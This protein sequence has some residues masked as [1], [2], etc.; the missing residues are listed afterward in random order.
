MI[1]LRATPY[2]AAVAGVTP[3]AQSER[4]AIIDSLRG[5]ALLGILLMN[6]PVFALPRQAILNLNVRN[7]YSG[8]NYYTWWIVNGGFEGTMRA[9][10][11]LLFGAGCILL[12]ERLE[13]KNTILSAADI[14]YR[15]L[16]WLLIFGLIDA[17]IF[18]WYGDILFSYAV[19]GLFLFPFRKLKP[20][21]L[22]TL[23]IV[24]ML[25]SGLRSTIGLYD[26]ASVRKKGEQVAAILKKDSTVK[27]TDEQKADKAKYDGLVERR[28]IENIRKEADKNVKEMNKGYFAIMS[29]FKDINVSV[30]STYLYD[31]TF[32]DTLCLFF[33]GMAL[34]RWGVLT[35]ERSKKF[36]WWL[37]IIG[38]GI[39]LPVSYYFLRTL[40][41]VSFDW[42]RL[43]D[44]LIVDLYQ[45][46]R[47]FTALGHVG[48]VML[49]Y[50][51]GLADRFLAMMAK[52]G[53]MAFTNYL[54]Q[55][56]FCAVIFYG[57]GFAQF[58]LL[59]RYQVYYVAGAIWLFQ[60]IF[61]NIWLK[62]Y[63]FGPFEWLWRSLVYWKLQPMR[64]VVREKSR[65]VSLAD[66]VNYSFGNISNT[67][68]Q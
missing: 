5:I 7:E 44:R 29:K 33:I 4:I 21:W 68:V 54:C 12:I 55:S 59:E 16:I 39:G 42:S 24:I 49:I 36:Y 18:L 22:L 35:G 43:A 17:F 40:G 53:Q 41:A 63:Q 6:I 9:L 1:T 32:W 31:S 2:G 46:K 23:G 37:M 13:K 10:F 56:V 28:K 3:V 57:F 30:Q 64:K 34:F 14:Y 47:T 15:R 48:L 19:C 45:E 66:V 38:Y 67:D 51:Y 26:S 60:I 61:S 25:I 65:P 62:F 50:K 11:S 8:A 27:L 52:V 58:G 20:S